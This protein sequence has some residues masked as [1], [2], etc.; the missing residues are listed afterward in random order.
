MWIGIL[1]ALGLAN[2]ITR[3]LSELTEAA[4]AVGRGNLEQRVDI[5]TNDE[6]GQLG[7]VF[8]RMTED[9]KKATELTATVTQNLT[10][11]VMLLSKD[12]QILWANKKVKESSGFEDKDIIGNF[13]YRVTHARKDPCQPP[14]DICP[15]KKLLETGKPTVELHTHFDKEGNEHHV[16]VTVEAVRDKKGEI[17]QFIHVTRDVTEI[18]KAKKELE[19][20]YEEIKKLNVG[21]EQKVEERTRA[22]QQTQAQLVQSGKLAAIGQLGAGVAHELNN[23]VGGILGYAQYLLGKITKPDFQADN[24]KACKKYLGYIEKEAKRCKT[25]VE[26]LLK[27]SRR[28][29]ERFEPININQVIEDTLAITAHQLTMKKVKLS[30][31]LDPHLKPVEGNANQLQ[32]VFTNI[33]LNAQ[34]AMPKGGTLTIATRLSAKTVEISF[35]DTGRGIP[36]ENLD[37]IFDPF[38]TT[39]IDWRGTGL[40]LSVSYEIIQN[41]QGRIEV[42]SEMDKGTTF[43][44]S[45]PVKA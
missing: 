35:T 22:L 15:V 41:H 9:L 18:V 7:K 20:T 30:Q 27:F 33:I 42:K 5:R 38:F 28:S 29:P 1:I 44:I 21:L 32:Q 14:H 10:E 11:G 36:Q 24:C 25:I 45:L 17:I 23:P 8:N 12:F 43:T 13:C 39:K 31:D 37:K 16:E 26:N 34:Q 40:G 4:R 3:P 19:K 2:F 6:I